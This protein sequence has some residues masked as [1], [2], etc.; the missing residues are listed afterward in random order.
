MIEFGDTIYY[1][2]METFRKRI[3]LEDNKKNG[4]ANVTTETTTEYDSNSNVISTTVRTVSTEKDIEIDTLKYD[5][6]S[7]MLDVVLNS[8]TEELDASLGAER[9]LANADLP[10]KIAFNT[11]INYGILKEKQ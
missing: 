8:N 5:L 3:L 10:F 11:L 6:F 4:E 2:D 7:R 9:A 1:V